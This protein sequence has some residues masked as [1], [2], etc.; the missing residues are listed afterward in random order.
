[1]RTHCTLA[2]RAKTH[3]PALAG[4]A[5]CV[6]VIGGCGGARVSSG[7]DSGQDARTQ[8]PI[9]TCELRCEWTS[10]GLIANLS[11]KNV[12][13]GDVSL[14]KR[15][16]LIDDEAT[17]LTWSPFEVTHRGARIPYGGKLVKRT[18]PT[19]EDYR[20]LTP[21]EV[22]SATVNVGSAYDLSAPG[23]YHIR[24]ASVNFPPDAQKRID[25]ASNAVEIAKPESR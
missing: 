16:L 25:I 14:L 13:D 4:L 10:E 24:Y 23:A 22:V 1:M 12:S 8:P 21:G 15:N 2:T 17:D 7:V 19:G 6:I 11:F 9:V 18:P 3:T 20:V 5:A